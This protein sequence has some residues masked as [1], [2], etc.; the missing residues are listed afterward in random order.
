LRSPEDSP[1]LNI[2]DFVEVAVPIFFKDSLFFLYVHVP[3]T[4]GTSIERFF[5]DNGFS[6]HLIDGGGPGSLL[7]VLK[8]SPQHLHA[9]ILKC[10]LHLERFHFI[11]MTVRHPQ[12]RILSEYSMRRRYS[13]VDETFG[14]WLRR[15]LESY[16]ENHYILDN[17]IRP[18]AEFFLPGTT[19]YRQEDGFGGDW[20]NKISHDTGVVFSNRHVDWLLKE[21]TNV[22]DLS[23]VASERALIEKF[24]ALDFE[25]FGYE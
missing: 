17:H 23:V 24:Y 2:Q 9:T 8:S 10:I 11:F 12:T 7:P 14:E 25:T 5:I 6:I 21:G 4:G 13:G 20:I 19:F 15:T 16:A 18:Q 1:C 3:K 22:Q